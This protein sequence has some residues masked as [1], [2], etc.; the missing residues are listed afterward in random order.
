MLKRIVGTVKRLAQRQ[1][2]DKRRST[3]TPITDA[4]P[5]D[6]NDVT[7]PR[8]AQ[9]EASEAPPTGSTSEQV[10]SPDQLHTVRFEGQ[11]TEI[12]VASGTSILDAAL[13]ADVDLNNYCGG[14]CS[15]GSC[16]VIVISGELSELDDIEEATLDLVRESDRDRL[17]CQARVQGDIKIELPPQDF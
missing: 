13:E 9:G 2:R 16:R 8:K 7:G 14:M 1:D 11:G 12:Q 3:T 6:W 15:C 4:I 10:Q 17:G 5:N